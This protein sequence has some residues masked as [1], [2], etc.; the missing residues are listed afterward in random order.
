MDQLPPIL[1]LL[2]VFALLLGLMALGWRR[3]SRR[4]LATGLP[5][6]AP[7][8]EPGS[9][10]PSPED[11]APAPG[12][13]VSTT[14]AEQHLERVTAHGL[15][16]RSRV[17]VSRGSDAQGR[18]GWRLEREGAPSLLVPAAAVEAVTT[19]PGMVGKWM[20]GDALLVLR[21]RLG[22]TLLDTGLRLDSRDDHER[23][24]RPAPDLPDPSAPI[25]RKETP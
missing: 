17:L 1:V 18:A 10:T 8:P 15:G 23:L 24:L 21:W 4:Q 16:A 6:P 2:A 11:P 25:S 20:G 9:W 7:V 22:E 13:Y 14:L 5:A 12:V 3:R 19:A